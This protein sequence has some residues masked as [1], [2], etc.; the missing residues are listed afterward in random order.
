[1]SWMVLARSFSQ[2][3]IL[4]KAALASGSHDSFDLALAR[5]SRSRFSSATFRPSSFG[6]SRPPSPPTRALR[7]F[8]T[9]NRSSRSPALVLFGALAPATV[10]N[11]QAVEPLQEIGITDVAQVFEL[12]HRVLAI[13]PAGVA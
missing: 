10:K 6:S 8:C 9:L 5:K 1:M 12:R 3:A 4:S 2:A 7:L 13:G 11:L